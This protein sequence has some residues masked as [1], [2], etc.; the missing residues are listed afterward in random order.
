MAIEH[1]SITFDISGDYITDTARSWFYKEGK[2][3]E[4]VE[5][6]LLDCLICDSLSLEKRKEIAMNIIL[7]R[8]KITGHTNDNT[9]C[10]VEDN[11]LNELFGTLTKTISKLHSDLEEKNGELKE[12]TDKYLDL[13]DG[14]VQQSVECVEFLDNK[15]ALIDLFKSYGDY[16]AA[17]EISYGDTGSKLLDDFLE[18]Q[19]HEDNYGW[20]SPSG[21]FSPA[22]FGD[23]EKWAQEYIEDHN[24][25][26]EYT[27]WYS[28]KYT[29]K[30]KFGLGLMGDFLVYVKG[31]VLLHNP[32]QGLA[33]VTSNEV[34][35]LTKKQREFLFDYYV[36]RN[37]ENIANQFIIE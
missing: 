19:R 23:H 5:E 28:K 9:Y 6:L 24:L 20:L 4:K 32:A 30:Q 25:D 15:R 14:V 21:E 8:Q 33:Q 22:E 3:Y 27:Q 7:G 35:P 10:V 18:T 36:E 12:I 1:K 34:K 31:F 17:K 29:E 37:Q 13:Y 26:E 2:P 11:S 16:G